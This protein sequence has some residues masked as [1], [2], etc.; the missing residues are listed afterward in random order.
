MNEDICWI[1]KE[2]KLVDFQTLK[3]FYGNG[4]AIKM[5]NEIC[6]LNWPA[7]EE[8]PKSFDDFFEK[9]HALLLTMTND[10]IGPCQYMMG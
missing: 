5:F 6:F 8:Y 9:I 7:G 1:L 4:D 2:Q 10:I 3:S